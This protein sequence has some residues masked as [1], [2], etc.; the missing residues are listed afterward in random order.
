MNPLDDDTT[1]RTGL[2]VVFS[3]VTILLISVIIWVLKGAD[4]APPRPLLPLQPA[5]QA[6]ARMPAPQLREPLA[7]P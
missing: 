4:G 6:T 2:W 7:T 3:T 5:L 1:T